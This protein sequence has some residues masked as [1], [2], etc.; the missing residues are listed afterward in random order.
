MKL[1]KTKSWRNPSA[2]VFC[3]KKNEVHVWR[4]SLKKSATRLQDL[5][6]LLSDKELTRAKRYYFKKDQ[7]QFAVARGI[8]RIL[9]GRYLEKN[10]AGF[11]LA[12]GDHGKPRL[13]SPAISLNLLFNVSHSQGVAL[14]A[15][16]R[17]RELGVDV[18][19]IKAGH[20]MEKIARRY[21]SPQ[22]C[23]D[24]LRCRPA[25]R[26]KIYYQY[27]TLKEALLKGTGMGLHLPL[28]KVEIPSP[29]KNKSFTL[30]LSEQ[31]GSASWTLCRLPDPYPGYVAALAVEGKDF[32]LRCLDF[33][34]DFLVLQ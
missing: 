32:S 25:S 16:C 1:S 7:E 13:S 6:A 26:A 20:D 3:L 21:F 12:E 31:D 27:W 28:D 34:E 2:E 24:I 30:R 11:L 29:A 33:T 5:Q 10:P 15:I 18:E 17:G 19:A 23:H 4:A 9:L 22:E 14:F 8:L